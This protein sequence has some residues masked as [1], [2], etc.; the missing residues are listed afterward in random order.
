MLLVAGVVFLV[1]LVPLPVM[2]QG[3]TEPGN[4]RG[5]GFSNSWSGHPSATA[6]PD[7]Y[8]A[9]TSQPDFLGRTAPMSGPARDE[10][11]TASFPNYRP[12]FR[13]YPP[14]GPPPGSVVTLPDEMPIAI[15][16]EEEYLPAEEYVFSPRKISEFKNGFFQKASFRSTYVDR[17][18]AGDVGITDL[19]TYL[20]VAVSAP[21]K[22][23]PLMISPSFSVHY[24][25]GPSGVGAPA[26][27]AR[28]HDAFV[29]FRWMTMWTQRFGFEVAFIP[30]IYS[31]FERWNEDA[32]RIKGRVGSLYKWTPDLS[33][34]LG[35]TYLDREDF[36]VLPIAGVV[37][38]PNDLWRHE[39]VFPE[40]KISRR[41]DWGPDWD[42]WLYLAAGFG[43]D[44]YSIEQTPGTQDILTY[45]D[46][47]FGLGMERKR[48]GGGGRLLEI[49]Y[50]VSR[51]F[52]FVS[53]LPDY[54]PDD[55]IMVRAGFA[56]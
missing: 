28:V 39:F 30:G 43:G 49:G 51:Q 9:F 31:D 36:N 22:N 8:G 48:N 50:V 2:A 6:S 4:I 27:P 11:R 44:S 38:T 34:V 21:T 47:R 42:D 13:P 19:E 54:K 12:M 20:T 37:W 45:R 32:V 24:F 41:F 35:F 17:G 10:L 52:E 29:E 56:Y 26:L 5:D 1:P 25:D 46:I 16:A 53:G 18:D 33:F 40:V 55:A 15:S 7:H 14:G 3:W 23:S